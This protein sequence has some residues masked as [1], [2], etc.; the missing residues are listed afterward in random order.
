MQGLAKGRLGEADQAWVESVDKRA[1]ATKERL[2][3]ELQAARTSMSKE[4]I[5]LVSSALAGVTCFLSWHLV[6]VC[7]P[8]SPR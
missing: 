3:G 1:A 6:G 7:L 5:R 4:S 2:E 8:L